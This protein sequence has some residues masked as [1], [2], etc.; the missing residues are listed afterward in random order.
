MSLNL[1]SPKIKDFLPESA[2]PD[3]VRPLSLRRVLARTCKALKDLQRLQI[4]NPK[5]D[6]RHPNYRILVVY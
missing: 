3:A 6:I 4:R 1:S 5:S 2:F